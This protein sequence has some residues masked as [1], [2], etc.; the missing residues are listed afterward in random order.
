MAE[1]KQTRLTDEQR[2]L[3]EENTRIVYYALRRE[4]GDEF[5][6]DEDNISEGFYALCRAAMMFD[7]EKGYKFSSY[8]YKAV[9]NRI[10]YLANRRKC[11][12][13]HQKRPNLSLDARIRGTEYILADVISDKTPGPEQNV[14]KE[15]LQKQMARLIEDIER[16]EP[17]VVGVLRDKRYVVNL[18]DTTGIS[19]QAIYAKFKS[20]KGRIN[21]KYRKRYG[22]TINDT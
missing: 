21:R 15:D 14:L 9:V 5:V 19:H 12:S 16:D 2:K 4:F 1:Y 10:R 22:G 8:A 11:K 7:P 18:S 17:I 6:C 3:V 13:R 20:R